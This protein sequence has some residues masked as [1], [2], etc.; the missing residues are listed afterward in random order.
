MNPKDEAADKVWE[1]TLPM[2]R[3]KRRQRELG[4]KALLAA[5]SACVAFGAY[6]MTTK[7]SPSVPN[8]AAVVRPA[9]EVGGTIAVIRVGSD[10]NA[11]LEELSNANFQDAHLSFGLTQF[12]FE[13]ATDPEGRINA[14][15]VFLH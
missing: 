15:L 10:G 1:L 5:A 8:R 9:L 6:W 3:R 12:V 2:I 4:R 7:P 13:D 14:D 11:V